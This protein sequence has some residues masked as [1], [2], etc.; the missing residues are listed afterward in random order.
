MLPPQK[1]ACFAV[2]RNPQ[3]NIKNSTP[4]KY[5]CFAGF[6]RLTACHNATSTLQKHTCFCA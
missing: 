6:F 2:M 3:E 5:A 4:Q 1:L